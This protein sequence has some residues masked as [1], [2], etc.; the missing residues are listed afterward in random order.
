[1]N[2]TYKMKTIFS[3]AFSLLSFIS[4]A[5]ELAVHTISASEVDNIEEVYQKMQLR[6]GVTAFEYIRIDQSMLVNEVSIEVNVLGKSFI[7]NRDRLVERDIDNYSWFGFNDDKSVSSIFTVLKDDIVGF[8]QTDDEFYYIETFGNTYTIQVLDRSVYPKCGTMNRPDSNDGDDSNSGSDS[9]NPLYYN[10]TECH[11]RILALYTQAAEN[12]DS[13][14]VNEIQHAADQ[15]NQSFLNSG[16]Y[17]FIEIVYV[18]KTDYVENTDVKF[19]D[20]TPVESDLA[21]FYLKNDGYMDNVHKLRDDFSADICVLITDIPKKFQS[22]GWALRLKAKPDFAF[23]NVSISTM[24]RKFTFA[25][26]IGHLF[27]A[28]HATNEVT[29][30]S[31]DFFYPYAHAFKN[32]GRS[33]IMKDEGNRFLFYSNPDVY[34][35]GDKMGS[36]VSADNARFMQENMGNVMRYRVTKDIQNVYSADVDPWSGQIFAGQVVTSGHVPIKWGRNY[37]FRGEYSV[38]LDAGFE[39]TSNCQFYA[40]VEQC[41]IPF[42]EGQGNWKKSN[43]ESIIETDKTITIYPNPINDEFFIDLDVE[44]IQSVVIYSIDGKKVKEFDG[45]NRYSISELPEG[46]Y[47]VKVKSINSSYISRIVKLN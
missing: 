24:T 36:A 37:S 9:D 5:Q 43:E 3:I 22:S 11:V 25:H 23:A 13:N 35:G 12:F 6:E 34:I 31:V 21:R 29:S 32:N 33:T 19:Y 26:E 45:F 40:Y 46:I 4:F 47:S 44:L 1:M 10:G 15:M 27:G 39:T 28:Q 41:G 7:L 16:I 38:Y 8:I 42:D 30:T 2:R 18:E 14:V 17:G 20:L